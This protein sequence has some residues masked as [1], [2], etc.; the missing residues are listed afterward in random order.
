[1]KLVVGLGN[2][3][4][5]YAG[6]RHN[7]GFDVI[8]VLASRWSVDLGTERFHSWFGDTRIHGQRV[9]LLKPTTL[10]NRSGRAVLAAG[11][12]FKLEQADLLVI[13]DDWALPVGR[14]RMRQQGSAGGHKG[15]QD[16]ID[17][18]GDDEWCRLRIGIGEAIGDPKTYV[19]QR[20]GDED[21]AV[22]DQA[23]TRAADAVESWVQD[24][25][26]LAMTRFNGGP[27]ND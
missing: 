27:P 21:D 23:R 5:K 9:A 26:D 12:F 6:T 24:G 1:M 22:M 3:G 17:R 18:L 19:L 10:M 25:P 11:Q 8:D 13:C 7:V 15:L 4:P 16:I 2:A 14:L 20:F